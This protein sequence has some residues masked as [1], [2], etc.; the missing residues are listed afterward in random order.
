MR[1]DTPAARE[2]E[3]DMDVTMEDPGDGG[4]STALLGSSKAEL[5][6]TKREQ[7]KAVAA[8]EVSEM[9]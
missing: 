2:A 1:S 8:D 6:A 3:S 7:R 9:A 4:E 5:N